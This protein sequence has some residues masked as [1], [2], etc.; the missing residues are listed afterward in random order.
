MVFEN[1]LNLKV[2]T[3]G[4]Q[5]TVRGL[6]ATVDFPKPTAELLYRGIHCKT[7]KS[8]SY[9]LATVSSFFEKLVNPTKRLLPNENLL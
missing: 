3:N 7:R 8:T 1:M 9:R 5:A 4:R 6:P 2:N